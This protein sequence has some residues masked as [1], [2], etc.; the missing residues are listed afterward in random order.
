MEQITDIIEP[1]IQASSD[2]TAVAQAA[3]ATAGRDAATVTSNQIASQKLDEALTVVNDRTAQMQA[4]LD[5]D[6]DTKVDKNGVGQINMAMLAT[7]VK[8]ALTGGSTHIWDESTNDL[9]A[10]I[11]LLPDIG[12]RRMRTI[13]ML[14][15][16]DPHAS[17]LYVMYDSGK[18]T[19]T[20]IA[21]M[22]VYT[23]PVL[24][25]ETVYMYGN[26]GDNAVHMVFSSRYND[27]LSMHAG[28]LTL[29]YISGR[30]NGTPTSGYLYEISVPQGARWMTISTQFINKISFARIPIQG[31]MRKMYYDERLDGLDTD[32]VTATHTR[33]LVDIPATQT[34]W[35]CQ[36]DNGKLLTKAAYSIL[37]IL[38]EPGE[39]ISFNSACTNTHVVF[40]ADWIPHFK[41]YSFAASTIPGMYV[42][43]FI[44]NATQGYT[45]PDGAHMMI[46]SIMTSQLPVAQI[47]RGDVSTEY[48]QCRSGILSSQI[49]DAQGQSALTVGVGKQ[50]A[51]ISEAVA[52]ASDSDEI[53]VYPGVYDESVHAWGKRVRIRGT[54]K[55]DCILTHSALN[56]AD[57]PLEMSHGELSNLTIRGTNTGTQTGKNHA[58][59]MHAE[60]DTCNGSSLYVHDVIFE[61]AVH[62]CVGIG[63]RNHYTL[64][65]RDCEFRA[66]GAT[67]EAVYCHDHETSTHGEDDQ[68]LAI[69][70]CS[71]ETSGGYV[72]HLQSQEINGNHATLRAQRNILVNHAK[73]ANM[74]AMSK[75][76][77]RDEGQDGLL[78]SYSWSLDATSKTNTADVLNATAA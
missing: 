62:A 32:K 4:Q 18:V 31:S 27:P 3:G 16:A 77:G 30:L 70:D 13:G 61:N 49:L 41:E 6:L 68:H 56:Y 54:S 14:D 33:N 29:G 5:D 64:E 52:A 51:T 71:L 8:T 23:M 65:F 76:D 22:R 42:S 17:S 46:V 53:L 69:I 75:W 57:P 28:D 15:L 40:F 74:V 72:M 36:Y 73:P 58:Y 26:V 38:V 66:T 9:D 78:G 44:A 25:G 1:V 19:Q 67:N 24:G 12:Y 59:C 2:V 47:E 39:K 10:E 50:Y 63:L 45:V 48:V 20:G 35:Y 11:A 21:D 55:R 60:D 43:G 34:G 37:P 7:D